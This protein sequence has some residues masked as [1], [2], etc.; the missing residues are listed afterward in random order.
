MQSSI[1]LKELQKD[2]NKKITELGQLEAELRKRDME[3]EHNIPMENAKSMIMTLEKENAKL[4]VNTC[5]QKNNS[6]S[7]V[8]FLILSLYMW[9]IVIY[10]FEF[11]VLIF[12]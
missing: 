7:Y 4:K 5:R 6:F 8:F 9:T 2:L 11:F 10:C 3:Q 1:E 12:Q